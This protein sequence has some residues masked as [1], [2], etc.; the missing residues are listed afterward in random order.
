MALDATSIAKVKD[1]ITA[2]SHGHGCSWCGGHDFEVHE[3]E[4][5]L[6]DDAGQDIGS[7]IAVQ[8]AGCQQTFLFSGRII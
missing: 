2:K 8:C 4:I 5:N 7:L 6:T 3:D 1:W